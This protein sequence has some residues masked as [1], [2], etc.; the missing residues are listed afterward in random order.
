MNGKWFGFL[1]FGSTG[2]FWI[3]YLLWRLGATPRTH[4]GIDPFA[5]W[6]A[7]WLLVLVLAALIEISIVVLLRRKQTGAW[8]SFVIA[9]WFAQ[10]GT[11]CYAYRLVQGV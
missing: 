1:L 11:I 10:I 8:M 6:V 7:I 2:A 9:G 5:G 3:H 4:E